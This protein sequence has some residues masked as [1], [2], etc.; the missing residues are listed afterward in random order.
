MG[1]KLRIII[2]LIFVA[3]IGM[4]CEN[5]LYQSSMLNIK[6]YH[7]ENQDKSHND[8]HRVGAYR[9]DTAIAQHGL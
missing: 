6:I 4:F 3:E 2:L 1:G 8:G 5:F 9:M 7:Y